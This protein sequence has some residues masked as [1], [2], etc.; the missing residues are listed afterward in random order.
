VDHN[1]ICVVV[2]IASVN[3]GPTVVIVHSGRR[4]QGVFLS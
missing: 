4:E 3:N 2:I 1:S